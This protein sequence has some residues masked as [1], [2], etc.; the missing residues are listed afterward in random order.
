MCGHDA[1]CTDQPPPRSLLD[2]YEYCCFGK[3]FKVEAQGDSKV[4]ACVR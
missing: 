1:V 2:D 3:V 4:V